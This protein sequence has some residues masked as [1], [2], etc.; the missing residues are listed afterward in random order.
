M[1]IGDGD[2]A[3]ALKEI[4]REDRLFF[5]SGVSNSKETDPKEFQREK[6]LLWEQYDKCIH[7]IRGGEEQPVKKIIYFSSLSCL[8]TS[9]P[10]LEHK[11][12]MEQEVKGFPLWTIVRIG[13]IDWGTN[14]NTI[15]NAMRNRVKNGEPLEIRD[16]YKYITNKDELL[17]WTKNIPDW[18]CEISIPGQRMTVQEL[19]NKYVNG[20][21]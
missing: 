2:L 20:R 15:I 7:K 11:R 17:Y 21:K 9:T 13:N 19:V 5:V 12:M 14:P 8:L 3:Q 18:N 4:D 16:E 10:Y 1:I 6:D